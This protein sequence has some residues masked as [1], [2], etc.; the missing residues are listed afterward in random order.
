MSILVLFVLGNGFLPFRVVVLCL[1]S[2]FLW[3]WVGGLEVG[4]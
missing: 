1:G 3:E 2:G 4:G